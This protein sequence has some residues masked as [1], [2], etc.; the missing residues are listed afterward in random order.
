[1]LD[2]IRERAQGWLAKVI[3]ALIT[4]PF[5]LWGV[6]SYFN[7]SGG[8]DVVAKVN[9]DKITRQE[10]DRAIKGQQQEMRA[11]MGAAYN[12]ALFDDPKIRQGVLDGL[13]SQHLI[14]DAARQAKM[15]VSDAHLAETIAALPA[16]QDNGQFSQSRYDQV[17][18]QQGMSIGEFENRVRQELLVN[19][20]RSVFS[21]PGLVPGNV[22]VNFLQAYEQK[23]EVSLATLAPEQFMAQTQVSP[24]EIQRWYD[25]HKADYTLPAQ[26]RFGY[27]VLS[28]AAMANQMPVSEAAIQQYYQQN[29]AKY[30]EPEQRRASHILIAVVAG[31]DAQKRAAAKAK[32]EAI[33]LQVK[34]N[35]AKFAEI[36]KRDSSDAGSAVQGG[37]LGWFA[38]NAMVKPFSDAAF[39]M[40]E[41]QIS[42]PVLSE[43]GYHIIQLTGIKPAKVQPLEAVKADITTELQ[44]QQG[45]KQFADVAETFSNQVYEQSDSLAPVAKALK[46]TVQT[47]GW[48]T[49]KGGEA[50]GI[51]NNPKMI[52]ALFSDDV[53][54]N[55]RN[56]E[57]IEV[58]SGTLA[59][60]R[61]LDYKPAALQPLEMVRVAIE[62]HLKRTQAIALAAKQGQADLVQL[63]AG[64][65]PGVKW[66]DFMTVSRQQLGS[67]P[68]ALL[69]P[70]FRADI[71]ALPV[72]V[73]AA[74][75]NGVYTL[76]RVTRV[77][78]PA[79][80]DAV[81]VKAVQNELSQIIAQT[82][83]ADYLVS[84][85]N[86]AKI[87]I[88]KT[89]LDKQ[90]Q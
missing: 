13:V 19:E 33:Y 48:I 86:K 17:L 55:K 24:A 79:P 39:A 15:V 51:L 70:V 75:T 72:Y 74:D 47:S 90:A 89:A 63:R 30:R 69:E 81:K 26:A 82:D 5:M 58:A 42:T 73:G 66:T 1:M 11:S 14:I 36:A 85:K 78:A 84:L 29:A 2:A 38:R 27:V 7:K 44:N 3:L 10:F 28:Q 23:R 40:K 20:M 59:S 77:V 71:K 49:R 80:P 54:K 12:P 45:G 62:A 65:E 83:F 37:D 88:Q 67:L 25:S 9:G 76:A 50:A 18:R 8:D 87:E 16:F 4:I 21:A 31:D 68:P 64:K 43:F 35:P 61:L 60:A 22:V 32:A 41:G 52:A 56:T 57:A 34:A 46:L 53:L 6:E